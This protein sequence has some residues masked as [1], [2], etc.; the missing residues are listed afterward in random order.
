MTAEDFAQMMAGGGRP[1]EGNRR[2]ADWEG[3]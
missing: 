2:R 1:P 3:R